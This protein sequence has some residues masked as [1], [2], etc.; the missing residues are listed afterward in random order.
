M[1]TRPPSS[2]ATQSVE[3]A[4]ETERSARVLS[5]VPAVQV[6]LL[7]VGS[8]LVRTLPDSSTATQSVGVGQE[9]ELGMWPAGPAWVGEDQ[10]TETSAAEADVHKSSTVEA[11]MPSIPNM[12]RRKLRIPA[13]N[14]PA[15]RSDRRWWSSSC[16]QPA[17]QAAVTA[18]TRMWMG[19]TYRKDMAALNASVPARVA[20]IG[21][22]RRSGAFP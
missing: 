13:V 15:F 21:K 1:S 19:E 9:I 14:K 12:W 10:A 11:A 4:H 22:P 17:M 5:I 3:E 20:Y 2:T 6:G 7:D 16:D 18:S 8:V